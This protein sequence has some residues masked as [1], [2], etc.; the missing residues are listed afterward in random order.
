MT[1][2][3]TDSTDAVQGDSL[4]PDGIKTVTL[5]ESVQALEGRR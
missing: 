4:P 2:T 5:E 3:A 1:T